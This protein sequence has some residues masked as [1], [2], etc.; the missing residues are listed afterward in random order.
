MVLG[1]LY[2]LEYEVRGRDP[3]IFVNNYANFPTR[4]AFD[5]VTPNNFRGLN[6]RAA[7]M[8]TK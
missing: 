3:F 5:F 8:H 2:Q 7:K 4:V 6:R 1:C